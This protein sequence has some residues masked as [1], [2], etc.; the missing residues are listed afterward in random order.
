MSDCAGA[1]IGE[2]WTDSRDGQL[3]C[4]TPGCVNPARTS[5]LPVLKL[6]SE[7]RQ[8]NRDSADEVNREAGSRA[9]GAERRWKEG[10]TFG[11][12]QRRAAQQPRRNRQWRNDRELGVRKRRRRRGRRDQLRDMM[13]RSLCAS[14]GLREVARRKGGGERE[15]DQQDEPDGENF[16][17]R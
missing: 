13:L 5:P 6:K 2:C 10:A 4:L 9:D 12:R 14:G 17:E 15:C 3:G 1:A 7:D 16:V 8:Q 11:C